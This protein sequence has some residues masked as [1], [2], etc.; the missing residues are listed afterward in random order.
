MKKN[1]AS[2]D[3][4]KLILSF[5]VV[6]IHVSPFGA[7]YS[8]LRFPIVRI[9][10]PLF[11]VMSGFL[12]FAHLPDQ[13][14]RAGCR[15]RLGSFVK[16]N[17]LLYLAWFVILIPITFYRNGY[18]GKSA[19]YVLAEMVKG[20]FFGSTFPASWYIMA[21]VICVSIVYFLR[22]YLNNTLLLAFGALAYVICTAASNYRGVLDPEGL[23]MRVIEAYPLSIYVGFPAGFYWI[24]VGK[25]FA[26]AQKKD[27][28]DAP[29][30]NKISKTVINALLAVL[31]FGVLFCEQILIDRLGSSWRNDCYFTL[32]LLCPVLF[33]LVLS[34]N[35]KCRHASRMRRMSTVIYCSHVAAGTVFGFV[36]R[37][38][39][40]DTDGILVSL[41][42]YLVTI[43]CCAVL[44]LVIDKLS[45]KKHLGWLRYLR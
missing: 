38:L 26:D 20:F 35:A 36:L 30:E 15:A 28:Q 7:E 17:M 14:D 40:A 18:F 23:V 6:A 24:A 39:G 27:A 12:F 34:W 3:I 31:L 21:T 9:A 13:S 25:S 32:M 41:L 42:V 4:A 44:S 16:R 29:G 45:E 8:Y 43:V 19:F 2:I 10:V 37:K 1:Y 33:S 11:F 22:K 5:I